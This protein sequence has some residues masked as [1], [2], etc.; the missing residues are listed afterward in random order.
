MRGLAGWRQLASRDA[1]LELLPP[2]IATL[3]RRMAAG[4]LLAGACRPYEV[5]WCA[6]KTAHADVIM[7]S[8]PYAATRVPTAAETSASSASLG[9]DAYMLTAGIALEF[10]AHATDLHVARTLNLPE[11]TA[12]AC[13]VF[14]ASAFGMIQLRTGSAIMIEAT[15]V[16]NAQMV[17]E[18]RQCFVA[19]SNE[20][21]AG[22]LAA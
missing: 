17:I 7:A 6:A 19:S 16:G 9:Y 21:H 1:F 11:A 13:S 18:K 10:C 14:V 2:A 4:T 3:Q 12:V 15:L 8:L 22:I 5:A 20:W